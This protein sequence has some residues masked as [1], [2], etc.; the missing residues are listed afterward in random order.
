VGDSSKAVVRQ[1]QTTTVEI[2]YEHASNFTSNLGT[3]LAEERFG[4]Q[5]LRPDA[6]VTGQ[7][8]SSPA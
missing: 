7:L 2:S 1:R 4:I 3:A 8:A 5:T 6:F